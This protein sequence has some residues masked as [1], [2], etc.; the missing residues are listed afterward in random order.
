MNQSLNAAGVDQ[1]EGGV[2]R[3][4]VARELVVGLAEHV[5]CVAGVVAQV[6]PVVAL[7]APTVLIV[8]E[9]VLYLQLLF[10][11]RNLAHSSQDA[12]PLV[13]GHTLLP[14]LVEGSALRINLDAHSLPQVTASRTLGAS[15][16]FISFDTAVERGRNSAPTTKQLKPSIATGTCPIDLVVSVAIDTDLLA[17]P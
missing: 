8:G 9:A 15:A 5:H 14:L 7:N 10:Y 11:L 12:V 4:A 2:A 3:Q 6:E 1:F 13:A 17:E 16:L